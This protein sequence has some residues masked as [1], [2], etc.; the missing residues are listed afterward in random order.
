MRV[1]ATVWVTGEAFAPSI[2]VDVPLQD[3]FQSKFLNANQD[4]RPNDPSVGNVSGMILGAGVGWFGLGYENCAVSAKGKS[5]SPG[6]RPTVDFTLNFQL[7][8]VFLDLP[9]HR[10]HPQIGHGRGRV[11][12]DFK[13]I[14]GQ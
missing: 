9:F 6:A 13:P 3:S 14:M 12:A 2:S 10:R 5:S 11:S 4:L 8:D 1:L 7:Y